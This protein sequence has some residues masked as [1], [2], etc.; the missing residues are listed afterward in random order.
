MYINQITLLYLCSFRQQ[1][2]IYSFSGGTNFV[3]SRNR[4]GKSNFFDA[5]QF[6]I[7]STKFYS[8][9]KEERQALL[10]EGLG[11]HVVNIFVELVFDNSVNHYRS[12]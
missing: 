3:V 2:E 5:L 4:S 11:S 10:H 6:L 1:P 7:L 12:I 8:L 9:R